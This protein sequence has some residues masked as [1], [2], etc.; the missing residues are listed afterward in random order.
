MST[1]N[2]KSKRGFALVELVIVLAIVAALCTVGVVELVKTRDGLTQKE[3]D[4]YAEIVFNAAQ[5]RLMEFRTTGREAVYQQKTGDTVEPV[6]G[7]IKFPS[8]YVPVDLDNDD[9]AESAF[10][11][12][13]MCYLAVEAK[14]KDQLAKDLMPESRDDQ[15]L[16]DGCWVIEF[17]YKSAMVYGVF[18]CEKAMDYNPDEFNALRES[19]QVREQSGK[20]VG[21]YG[22]GS[23]LVMSDGTTLY[24][25]VLVTN[26]EELTATFTLAVPEALQKSKEDVNFVYTIYQ[27]DDNW[28]YSDTVTVENPTGAS[29]LSYTMVLDSMTQHFSRFAEAAGAEGTLAP[30]LNME[31]DLDAEGT[32]TNTTSIMDFDKFNSLFGDSSKEPVAELSYPRHLQNLDQGNSK[33]DGQITKAELLN[34]IEWPKDLPFSPIAN[35][36]LDQFDGGGNSIKNLKNDPADEAGGLFEKFY[37]SEIKDLTL[38]KPVIS[39][40][41]AAGAVAAYTENHALLS[42]I[43]ITDPTI[44]CSKGPSGGLIGLAFDGLST[45]NCLVFHKSEFPSGDKETGELDKYSISSATYAG[46][47]LGEQ[48]GGFVDLKTSGAAT[49]VGD[50]ATLA[51]GGL[52][53]YGL[54]FNVEKAYA[55]CY[56]YGLQAGGLIGATPETWTGKIASSYAAG[57]LYGK[58]ANGGI[59][60]SENGAK[61]QDDSGLKNCYTVVEFESKETN[62]KNYAISN[63]ANA[64]A[65]KMYYLNAGTNVSTWEIA[66]E[67]ADSEIAAFAGKLSAD[68]ASKAQKANAYNILG[69][70]AEYPDQ[71]ENYD[72]PGIAGLPHY[73]DWGPLSEGGKA[74]V[75]VSVTNNEKLTVNIEVESSNRNNPETL[76]LEYTIYEI[77]SSSKPWTRDESRKVTIHYDM[78]VS[79]GNGKYSVTLDD[80]SSTDKHFAN[81]TLKNVTHTAQPGEDTSAKLFANFH[82]GCMLEVEATITGYEIV[83]SPSEHCEARF[84]SLFADPT[85]HSTAHIA[86]GRHLQNLDPDFSSVDGRYFLVEFDK[87]IQFGSGSPWQSAYPGKTFEPINNLKL[88]TIEGHGKSI[89]DLKVTG[90]ESDAAL[91]GQFG[92][93][94]DTSNSRAIQ[95]LS[96]VRAN[97]STTYS[98]SDAG[99]LVGWLLGIA[100]VK[101]CYSIDPI[102]KATDGNAGGLIG[103]TSGTVTISN[104]GV[105]L[106]KT[107]LKVNEGHT[108]TYCLIGT[109]ATGGLIGCTSGTKTTIDSCFAAVVAGDSQYTPSGVKTDYLSGGLVGRAASSS[110]TF[111]SNS[112]ADSYVSGKRAGGLVGSINGNKSLTVTDC[113]AA[114]YVYGKNME[115]GIVC[116]TDS[117]L[118]TIKNMYTMVKPSGSCSYYYAASNTNTAKTNVSVSNVY[119]SAASSVASFDTTA[120]SGSKLTAAQKKDPAGLAATLGSAFVASGNSTPY[121]LM[122]QKLEA[123]SYPMP[124]LSGMK[125]YG[126]W[127]LA[128]S[129]TGIGNG[130]VYYEKYKDGT[131]GFYSCAYTAGGVTQPERNTLCD[132]KVILGDG[133]GILFTDNDVSG[134]ATVKVTGDSLTDTTY[135]ASSVKDTVPGADGGEYHL[136]KFPVKQVD[137]KKNYSGVSSS[138]DLYRK[139]VLTYSNCDDFGAVSSTFYYDSHFAKCMVQTS[140]KPTTAGATFYLRTARQLYDM[141]RFYRCYSNIVK[142]TNFVQEVDIDYNTYAWSEG[143][144][145]KW[146]GYD[147][148]LSVFSSA[149][150]GVRT[151]KPEGQDPIGYEE[152]SFSSYS[153]FYSNYDGQNHKIV[154]VPLGIVSEDWVQNSQTGL[155]GDVSG[156]TIKNIILDGTNVT[157]SADQYCGTLAAYVESGSTI[158]NC[159]SYGYEILGDID[160]GYGSNSRSDEEYENVCIG[161]LIGYNAGTVSNCSAEVK[162][163]AP[164]VTWGAYYYAG[165]FVGYNKGTISNSCAVADILGDYDEDMGGG[166]YNYGYGYSIGSSSWDTQTERKCYLGGFAGYTSKK[167][168]LSGCVSATS[169]H[170]DYYTA[171]GFVASGASS[172]AP[173]SYFLKDST[174]RT[175][176]TKSLSYNLK[177]SYATSTDLSTINSKLNALGFIGTLVK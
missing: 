148:Y 117:K 66:M 130:F 136:L 64:S 33:V 161:G 56:V 50:P 94:D 96:L 108:D 110:G 149:K 54:N 88:K 63:F 142:G 35:K 162:K 119:Y 51:S 31:I 125:H 82:K 155:F 75:K 62:V 151:T 152:Y 85:G 90:S 92:V 45:E 141:S 70:Y 3:L 53:G 4:S 93:K 5:S 145:Y 167:N 1:K 113:Y 28:S 101:N 42:E 98:D 49:V 172:C 163:I 112:Y 23:A 166:G 61:G 11:K 137:H 29:V 30:G 32:E 65:T 60:L 21:Y 129:K 135:A 17:N 26:E 55:D 59:A 103:C 140:T 114:G 102:A 126:D 177:D 36:D 156:G 128:A 73:G 132:D 83:N 146:D 138:K 144:S 69:Q 9:S 43:N 44:S 76:P 47:I 16:W 67:S 105:Y 115:S 173:S 89:Y 8:G 143:Y 19:M 71:P 18:Y 15:K 86:Y 104:C 109:N 134:G 164:Y 120:I 10:E 81:L 78:P 13:E 25:K 39:A 74:V 133:Y 131:Y 14:E 169:I 154:G 122:D 27:M 97:C 174:K 170:G 123:N 20:N 127:A 79:S 168:S 80:L 7:L 106:T 2:R 40:I 57:Y 46:G 38:E 52:I 165:G 176:Y 95:N 139:I 121:N 160:P 41:Y 37:G 99:I 58:N 158:T 150:E 34:D 118:T 116:G 124:Q 157:L 111:I 48:K 91:F 68:F 12:G 159:H 6:E 77:N 147:L 175:F 107:D 87:D 153:R 171:K 100:D 84:C 72:Y 24:P 22:G